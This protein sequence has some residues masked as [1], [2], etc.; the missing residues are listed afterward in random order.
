MPGLSEA[1]RARER[2]AL[3]SLPTGTSETR[4]V[5]VKGVLSAVS[6][7]SIRLSGVKPLARTSTVAPGVID[8]PGVRI[9]RLG[10]SSSESG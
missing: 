2:V 4:G 6:A 3:P 7:A 8:A 9:S 10:S 1:G 5:R